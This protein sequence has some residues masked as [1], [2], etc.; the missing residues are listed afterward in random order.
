[1]NKLYFFSTCVK[2]MEK[3]TFHLL[4]YS[5]I[6]QGNSQEIANKCMAKSHWQRGAAKQ[7]RNASYVLCFFRKLWRRVRTFSAH[8][9][10]PSPKPHKKLKMPKHFLFFLS[11]FARGGLSKPGVP[12]HV[13]GTCQASRGFLP[14]WA[15]R[16]A[17]M[18]RTL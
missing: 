14:G 2:N 7:P 8:L 11:S 12:R 5:N 9:H 10:P 16:N 17:N 6:T 3:S 13:P 18:F 15:P 1:M 4:E